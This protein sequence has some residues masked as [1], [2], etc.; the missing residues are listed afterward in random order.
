MGKHQPRNIFNMNFFENNIFFTKNFPDNSN[1]VLIWLFSSNSCGN[2]QIVIF[3]FQ[4]LLTGANVWVL[5]IH[6]HP[7]IG[8]PRYSICCDN[9]Y[10]TIFSQKHLLLL[11]YAV[12]LCHREWWETWIRKCHIQKNKYHWLN[13]IFAHSLVSRII[14]ATNQ[15]NQNTIIREI[16]VSN[17]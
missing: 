4:H 16:C 2:V 14:R 9:L 6:F 17:F 8:M 12:N 1:S 5:E 15:V 13:Y 10:C 11:N 7:K 3:F